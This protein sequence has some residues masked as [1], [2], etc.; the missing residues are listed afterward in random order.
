VTQ[1]SFAIAQTL[2]ADRRHQ[3]SA[4]IAPALSLSVKTPVFAYKRRTILSTQSS[5]RVLTSLFFRFS[6]ANR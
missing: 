2:T 3:R 1:S 4:G 6:L 5:R